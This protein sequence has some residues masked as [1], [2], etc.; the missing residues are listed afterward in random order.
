MAYFLNKYQTV[1]ALKKLLI[2]SKSELLLLTPYLSLTKEL[3][4]LLQ[5]RSNQR[6]KTIFILREEIFEDQ[7]QI[8]RKIKNVT[9]GFNENLHAKCY[10]SDDM[11]AVVTSLNIYDYSIDNNVEFAVLL[12]K[13]E[14]AFKDCMKYCEKVCSYSEKYKEF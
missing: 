10:V 3:Q 7:Y 11:Y 4:N 8:L 9:I 14:K 12:E 2:E 5:K 6:R 13:E 1:E